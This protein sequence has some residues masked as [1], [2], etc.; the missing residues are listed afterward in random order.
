MKKTFL[1]ILSLSFFLIY[2]S[3]Q[4]TE[5]VK[6]EDTDRSTSDRLKAEDGNWGFTFNLSGLINNLTLESNTDMLGHE[7]IFVR[8]YLR[9]D[10]ALRVGFGLNSMRETTNLKDSLNLAD[11]EFDS[12]FSRTDVLV[13]A[14]VEKHLA[15]LRRLDPYIGAEFILQFI[16][17]EKYTWNET[18]TEPIGTTEIEGEYKLDGGTGIGA[19]A[20]LGFNYF[21]AKNISVG[22]EYRFGYNYIKM[23]GAF[24]ESLRTIPP[25]GSANTSYSQGTKER[26]SSGFE[27]NSSGNIIFSIFF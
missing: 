10:I 27:V 13:S 17:K 22:A 2:A 19:F 21:L 18:R 3:A 11:I 23:G 8:K 1:F 16:G 14:G 12:V 25:S 5:Q 4:E 7:I 26:K 6:S 24:S 15:N 20:L 9:D